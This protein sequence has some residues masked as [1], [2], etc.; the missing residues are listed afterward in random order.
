MSKLVNEVKQWF[1]YHI[2][3]EDPPTM[4]GQDFDGYK[5]TY[6][7]RYDDN[8]HDVIGH[9]FGI[10][11][12]HGKKFL[13]NV[14]VDYKESLADILET[15]NMWVQYD[16]KDKLKVVN[17]AWKLEFTKLTDKIID[18]NSKKFKENCQVT[19]NQKDSSI[20]INLRNVPKQV[21]NGFDIDTTK[22]LLNESVT[23]LKNKFKK[24]E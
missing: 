16:S 9:Q 14:P 17:E 6:G 22:K 18:E 8:L 2:E 4:V 24:D 20:H 15:L 21:L 12:K 1:I 5:V 7:A 13:R 11:S 23:N 10:V 3:S 19:V